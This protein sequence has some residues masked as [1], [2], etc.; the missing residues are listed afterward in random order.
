[1]T[2]AGKK[3]ALVKVIDS[4]GAKVPGVDIDESGEVATTTVEYRGHSWTIP[5]DIQDWPADVLVAF[6]NAHAMNGV[7]GALGD[8]QWR[9]LGQITGRTVRD[10][11]EL[12]ELLAKAAG[13]EGQ[14]E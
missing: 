5:S 4:S 8:D 1:M 13:F 7:K 3:D 10:V 11:S 2:A 6:E 12:F 14:G 9:R